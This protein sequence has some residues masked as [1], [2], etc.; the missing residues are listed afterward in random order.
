MP[1]AKLEAFDEMAVALAGF[2]RALS[3]PARIAILR[4]MASRGEAPCLDI[5]A[6]LPLSQPATSRHISELTKAGLLQAR[7]HGS[8][9]YYRLERSA[10]EAFCR[11]M[12][13]TLRP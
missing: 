1:Q 7:P 9:I 10:L 5:V 12:S 3:H 6:A 8:H 2:G 4:F 13:A 11:A